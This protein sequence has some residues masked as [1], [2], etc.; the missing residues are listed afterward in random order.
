MKHLSLVLAILAGFVGVAHARP[1]CTSNGKPVPCPFPAPKISVRLVTFAGDLTHL[2]LPGDGPY[3]TAPSYNVFIQR[4]DGKIDT[5]MG[6]IEAYP[7]YD[8]SGKEMAS[9]EYELTFT[10]PRDF[11]TGTYTIIGAKA[12]DHEIP[13]IY[14]VEIDSYK[15]HDAWTSPLD[16][17]DMAFEKERLAAIAK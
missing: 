4:P 7:R 15:N 17:S 14:T 5:T 1:T 9:A 6:D 10:W 12:F 8:A 16:S 2:I 3:E 13:L 11:T